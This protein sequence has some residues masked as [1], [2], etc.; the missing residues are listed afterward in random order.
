MPSMRAAAIDQ[1]GGPI[2]VHTLPVPEP[3]PD[4]LVF[5]VHTAGVGVWD[6]NVRSGSM[7]KRAGAH[8]SFPLVLGSDGAG[9]VVAV[10]EN[11]VRF[12]PGDE[13]WAIGTVNETGGF[14]AEYGLALEDHVAALPDAL[15]LAQ[16]G[17]LGVDA[18]T[19]MGGLSGALD[20]QSGEALM[21]YGASGGVGHLALQFAKRMGAR[22]L[23]VASGA[24]GVALVEALG[25]D[26]SVD[27]RTADVAAA[28]RRFAPD[29]LDAALVLTNGGTLDAALAEIKDGG[30]M[31][32]P[33]GVRP[34]PDVPEGVHGQ[35]HN[36]TLSLDAINDLVRSSGDGLPPFQVHVAEAFPLDAVPEA[37][38][39]LDAHY[40]GK[41]AVTVAG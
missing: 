19:A 37:L 9:T 15:P 30:R 22:V 18:A 40:V 39:A 26:A 33:N 35:A 4:Q 1:F 28:A 12:R 16:A 2:T 23:A 10:G 3:G 41:L 29:G 14:F 38:R 34:V 6:P 27:G 32:W 36:A 8:P 24:D 25:A 21:V 31:T 13:V 17:A 7:A 11:V 20:L 5:R